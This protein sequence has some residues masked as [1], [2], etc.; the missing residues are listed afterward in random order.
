MYKKGFRHTSLDIDKKG[1]S[2]IAWLKQTFC[3][4]EKEQLLAQ[5]QRESKFS[6]LTW[7]TEEQKVSEREAVLMFQRKDQCS[8]GH[9]ILLWAAKPAESLQPLCISLFMHFGALSSSVTWLFFCLRYHLKAQREYA[10]FKSSLQL[11][12]LDLPNDWVLFSFTSLSVCQRRC[13][14]ALS[15]SLQSVCRVGCLKGLLHTQHLLH[16]S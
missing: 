1:H 13:E 10:D 11:C 8:T 15:R 7:I 3:T 16:T 12:T 4:K 6:F 5:R 14:V 2:F 9:W